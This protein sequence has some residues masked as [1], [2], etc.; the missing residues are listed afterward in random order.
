VSVAGGFCLRVGVLA[1]RVAAWFAGGGGEVGGEGGG[2]FGQD[3]FAGV[4]VV[5][6]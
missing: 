5:V 6:E 1:G 2:D 4:G 3:E